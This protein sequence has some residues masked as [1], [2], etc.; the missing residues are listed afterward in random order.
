MLV[1][2]ATPRT[3]VTRVGDVAKTFTPVPVSSL[4]EDN[5]CADVIEPASVP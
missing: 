4:K 1:A 2:V 5:N 3:G